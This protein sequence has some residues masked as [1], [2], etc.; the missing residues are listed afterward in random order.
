MANRF[1]N[2]IGKVADFFRN[3]YVAPFASVR[4]LMKESGASLLSAVGACKKQLATFAAHTVPV[5]CA[6]VFMTTAF[7]VGGSSLAY[8]VTYGG[9]VIGYVADKSL[10]D[11]VSQ[12]MDGAII[13]RY[14]RTDYVLSYTTTLAL[15]EKENVL[16]ETQLY[17]AMLTATPD[18]AV[19]CGVYSSDRLVRICADE[20]AARSAV[21]SRLDAYRAAHT[22]CGDIDFAYPVEYKTGLFPSAEVMTAEKAELA[23]QNLCV[24]EAVIKTETTEL[25]YSTVSTKSDKYCVGTTVVTTAGKK[26]KQEVTAKICYVNGVEVSREVLS[27]T[28]I[29]EPVNAVVVVGTKQPV[30]N[31]G[32]KLTWPIDGSA[33]YLI[34]AYWGDG[35]NHKA[36]DIAC[37]RG[38]AILAAKG[39]TVVE[40]QHIRNY[41][42]SNSMS[43][44]GYFVTIDHG[45]G[46]KT[47]YA[48]CDSISVNLGDVVSAGDVIATVGNT[49]RSS[50]PHLHFEYIENGVRV[51][52]CPYLGIK[53]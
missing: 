29:S 5:F 25:D 16:D 48:H 31:E 2:L 47:R 36:V 18:L 13:A 10:A 23:A 41:S 19:G 45:N 33:F 46:I 35:R 40:V 12:K 37:D 26:G 51:N 9:K 53:Y 50:G 43:S 44:Y 30:I 17:N 38:T 20:A 1:K 34:T 28:V 7:T 52:P 21:Q 24:A 14:G 49:G 6:A 27:S 22:D 39:G 11:T 4:R 32:D 8:K 3:V 42:S 15:A